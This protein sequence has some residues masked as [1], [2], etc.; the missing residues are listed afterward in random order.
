[1]KQSNCSF[2]DIIKLNWFNK[3]NR[4]SEA[5]GVY[6]VDSNENRNLLSKLELYFYI[7]QTWTWQFCLVLTAEAFFP[8]LTC[9]NSTLSLLLCL[10]VYQSRTGFD[11]PFLFNKTHFSCVN[12]HCLLPWS[13]KRWSDNIRDPV[14]MRSADSDGLTMMRMAY[15]IIEQCDDV[16]S[17]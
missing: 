7:L 15:V 1:M 14:S 6:S 4:C 9:C 16:G 13:S 8:P 3:N 12:L 17:L 10:L 5:F 2:P 11:F